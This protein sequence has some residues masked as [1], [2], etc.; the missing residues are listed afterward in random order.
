MPQNK[1][2][3]IVIKNLHATTSIDSIRSLLSRQGYITKYINVLKNRFTG[4][5][6]NIFEV[7]LHAKT[8][9][10]VDEARQSRGYN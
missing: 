4:I 2:V 7:K 6:L 9:K 10:N 5:P 3:R 1:G 8:V